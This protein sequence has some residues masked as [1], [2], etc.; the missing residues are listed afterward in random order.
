MWSI[1]ARSDCKELEMGQIDRK[2]LRRAT[3]R[4]WI[5]VLLAAVFVIA[6][7]FFVFQTNS[8]APSPKWEMG[9]VPFVPASSKYANG[10]WSPVNDAEHGDNEQ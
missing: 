8:K 9:G 3:G 5:L 7:A 6:S 1:R 2:T 4:T 10:Y